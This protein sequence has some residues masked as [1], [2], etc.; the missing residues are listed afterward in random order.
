MTMRGLALSVIGVALFVA[1]AAADA[2]PVAKL[3]VGVET[4]PA[5]A[6]FRFGGGVW[7]APKA[8]RLA[9]PLLLNLGE[10][11]AVRAALA[12]EVLAKATRVDDL[13]RLLAEYPLNGFLADRARAGGT[14]IV[15]LDAMPRFLA[16]NRS[17]ARLADGP[18]WARSALADPAGWAAVTEHVVRHFRDLGV[19][20]IYEV[21]NEPDH[22]FGGGVEDYVELYKATVVGARRADPGARIAGPS[23]SDWTA[24]APGGGRWVERFLDLAA[25]TPAP[26]VGLDRLPVDALTYHVFY[27]VPANHHARVAEEA[28]R[29]LDAR[30]YRDAEIICSEW[31][32][33]AEPPYPEGDLNGTFPGA[34]HVGATLIAMARAGID[35]QTFQ[36]MVDPG[37]EGYSGGVLTPAGAPRAAFHAFALAAEA[38][39]GRKLAVTS[40]TAHVDAAAFRDGDRIALLVAAFPPTELMLARDAFEPTA[41]ENPALLQ[42]VNAAGADRLER[43]LFRDGP[44]PD[45]S[46]EARAALDRTRA[47]VRAGLAAREPWRQ[48]GTVEVSLPRQGLR[49]L[50][51][52]AIDQASAAD[53]RALAAID[54]EIN[55]LLRRRLPE[56]MAALEAAAGDPVA[57]A[58]GASVRERL[59]GRAAKA[60]ATGAVAEVIARADAIW[61]EPASRRLA[62]AMQA[63]AARLDRAP[64]RVEGD[65]LSFAVAPYA[66]HLIVLAP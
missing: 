42:E 57:Q 6:V 38:A 47:A 14:V 26:E 30:G 1:A 22:A 60:R 7:R 59:D 5:P 35:R 21:W 62:E 23:L 12:W 51:H 32:I 16:R 27:R 55:A 39:R 15:T 33:A 9:E 20:A 11:G 53:P 4:G 24:G 41:L 29:W 54:A 61:F 43:F 56:A 10:G 58:Y 66:L 17:E 37:G 48:G 65:R 19:D 40:D 13:P 44:A 52:R 36:M 31:N 45:V 64:P 3:T 50:S 46:P 63:D 18:A 25:R 49:V 8:M 2:A 28:R 34:A